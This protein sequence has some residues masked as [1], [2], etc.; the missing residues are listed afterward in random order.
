MKKITMFEYDQFYKSLSGP[1]CIL[2]HDGDY[3]RGIVW[4]NG[5]SVNADRFPYM[6]GMTMSDVLEVERFN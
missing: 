3:D 4:P 5:Y 2:I 1:A 6:E